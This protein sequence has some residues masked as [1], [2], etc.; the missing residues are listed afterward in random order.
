MGR[1]A[2]AVESQIDQASRHLFQCV[3]LRSVIDNAMAALD[4]AA[5]LASGENWD[6]YGARCV[7]LGAYSHAR[8]FLALLPTTTPVPD[9]AVDP[10]GEI[11]ITWQVEPRLVFSVSVGRNGRLSYAGLFGASKTYGTEWLRA[12]LPEPVLDGIARVFALERT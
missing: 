4:G 8:Q 6:G 10:D 3:S 11:S 5:Q 12:E 2:A 9:V 1:D 7:D